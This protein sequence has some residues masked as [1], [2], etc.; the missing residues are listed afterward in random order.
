MLIPLTEVQGALKWGRRREQVLGEGWAT[1]MQPEL[2]FLGSWASGGHRPGPV[3][4]GRPE[5][6]LC[7]LLCVWEAL[8]WASPPGRG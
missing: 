5:P 7:L 4:G 1:S 8:S 6:Q 2:P 3:V